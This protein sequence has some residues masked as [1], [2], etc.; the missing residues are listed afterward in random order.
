M[1]IKRPVQVK[2]IL[3]EA[4]KLE[5]AK[6][7]ADRFDQ[8]KLELE[9]L[10]FQSKKMLHDAS[11]KSHEQVRVLQE[12]LREEEKKRTED[13]EQVSFQLEQIELL[14]IGTEILHSTVESEIEIKVGDIWDDVMKESAIIIRDGVVCEIRESSEGI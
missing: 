8:L 13:I 2:V 10:R 4:S 7:Y 3:T 12:R 9:Q 1:R 11:K 6:E 5:L 14:P